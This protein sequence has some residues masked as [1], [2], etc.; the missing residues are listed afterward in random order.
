LE[1]GESF[2]DVGVIFLW[3]LEKREIRKICCRL[4]SNFK[5]PGKTEPVFMAH[6]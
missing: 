3:R 2:F 4:N 1:V 6:P 5:E